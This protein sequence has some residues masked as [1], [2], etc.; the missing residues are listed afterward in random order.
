VIELSTVDEATIESTI[1]E[2]VALGWQFDG[3][4]F[5][6]RDAS[7]RPAM[8]FVLFT[9]LR[10]D[11]ED[12][13]GRT[14]PTRLQTRSVVPLPGSGESAWERLRRLAEDD[15]QQEPPERSSE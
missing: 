8:A 5:A 14:S 4:Q 9:R 7:K 12:S 3:V 6:M 10:R 11:Q 2:W 13:K 15:E 1:N